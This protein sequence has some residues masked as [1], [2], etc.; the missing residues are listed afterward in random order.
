[1]AQRVQF[2]ESFP[3]VLI[4]V[5]PGILRGPNGKSVARLADRHGAG[6]HRNGF[7]HPL[8]LVGG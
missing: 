2:L 3:G 5:V 6:K 8:L 4:L 7:D 1:M